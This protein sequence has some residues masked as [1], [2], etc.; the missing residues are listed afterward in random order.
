MD[1]GR[2]ARN[3]FRKLKGVGIQRAHEPLFG[4]PGNF[5]VSG[6][7]VRINQNA[8]VLRAEIS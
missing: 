2:L 5:V 1:Q 8:S 7:Y 6:L 4:Y 3:P